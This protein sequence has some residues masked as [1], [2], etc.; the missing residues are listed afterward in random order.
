L[1][2]GLKFFRY[3]I[4]CHGLSGKQQ[5]NRSSCRVGYSLKNVASCFH[6]F[7]RAITWLQIYVQL[8]GCASFMKIFFKMKIR[9]Q[10]ALLFG[11]SVWGFGSWGR[12]GFA[13][14]SAKMPGSSEENLLKNKEWTVL[15]LNQS[16]QSRADFLSLLQTCREL[17]SVHP[18]DCVIVVTLARSQE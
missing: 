15:P 13:Y 4:G 7:L 16:Q 8:H 2:A 1:P 11:W 17:D 9:K 14:R 12:G 18:V 10:A 3:G 6:P 5:Q